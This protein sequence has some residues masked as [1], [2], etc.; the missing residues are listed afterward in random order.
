MSVATLSSPSERVAPE[1]ARSV[2]SSGVFTSDAAP[3][4]PS[5]GVRDSMVIARAPVRVSFLG[6]G[7]DFPDHF[8]QH[9][10]AVLVTAIN[11]YAHVTVQPF[12]EEYFDHKIRLCYRRNEAVKSTAEIQHP[13]I[14]AALEKLGL[15]SGLEMHVM[16]DLPARTGLGSSSTFVVAMLH[17]LHAHCGRFRSA[18]DLADEAIE[19]E[20][21]ILGEAGG[22]QDQ[23]AA[24]HGGLCLVQFNSDGRYQV[25]P[26]PLPGERIQALEQHM[27]LVYT[28]IQRDSF[29][30][31]GQKSPAAPADRTRVLNRLSQLAHL[32]VDYLASDRPILRFGELLHAGWE[33]K[34]EAGA[35]SLPQIDEWYDAGMKAGATGGK[36]LGAG[37]GGFLL[38]IAEP[39]HHDAIRKAV[40]GRPVVNVRVG[41]PGSQIIFSQR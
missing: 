33:L 15:G 22:W 2:R 17:A 37:Q 28:E 12:L 20:R 8:R 34:K 32:G 6:G 9:G 1:P 26:I 3:A 29:S 38:F 11:R 7:T 23:I 5:P 14:R 36:L 40:G 30:V 27:L 24:A 10:G 41:A 18:R 39:R 13:A 25:Q 31:L 35:V 19:I 4:Y 16:A 21:V